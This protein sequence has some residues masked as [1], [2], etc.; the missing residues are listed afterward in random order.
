MNNFKS[1]LFVLV[2]SVFCNSLALSEHLKGKSKA[3]KE[4]YLKI[5]ITDDVAY[6]NIN[7][8]SEVVQKISPNLYQQ[9][10]PS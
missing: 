2:V 6:I 3:E 5:R 10:K 1:F 9:K 4:G 8:F 7:E